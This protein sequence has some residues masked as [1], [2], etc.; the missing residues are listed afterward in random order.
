ML[1]DRLVELVDSAGQ[2]FGIVLDRD[3][4]HS[5]AFFLVAKSFE[6]WTYFKDEE[7]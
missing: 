5:E 2:F 3:E 1:H 4:K 7:P 6:R